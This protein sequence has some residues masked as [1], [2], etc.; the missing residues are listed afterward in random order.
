VSPPSARRPTSGRRTR[1]T[2]AASTDAVTGWERAGR[3][4]AARER[5]RPDGGDRRAG[6]DP[7]SRTERAAPRR[8]EPERLPGRRP[9]RPAGGDTGAPAAAGNGRPASRGPFSRFRRRPPRAPARPVSARYR[10]RRLAAAL[11]AAVVLLVAVGLGTRVLLY[12]AGLADVEEVTVSGLS[13]VPEQVVRDAAAVTPGGP[14]ISVDT[15]G[16]A[17]RVAAVEGVASVEVRRAWPHTVEVDVTERVP[18][19]LWQTPQALFEVDGTGLPYRLAPAPPPGLPLL[20]FAGV[21][22]QD[23]STTAALSVLRDLTDPLRVQVATVEVAGVQV[24][25]GLADGRSVRWGGPERSAEK[26][27]V[28]GALL[29][30][31]GSVYDVSS[32][33]LPTVRR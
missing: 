4:R 29:Q 8:A 6:G 27:G 26:I 13:T 9:R 32:P 18:V 7:V 12:D 23:P 15:A 28:L 24:T 30:Q 2:T 17:G 31:P 19:A 3:G 21:A 20:A 22:P 14:L 33:D 10:R 11:A 5:A 25:L 16:I 1:G